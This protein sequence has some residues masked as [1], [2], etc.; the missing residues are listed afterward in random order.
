MK[1]KFNLDACLGPYTITAVRNNGTA[2]AC[3]GK[4]MDTLNICNIT[5]YKGSMLFC[6]GAVYHTRV[7]TAVGSVEYNV[8]DVPEM[9]ACKNKIT[10]HHINM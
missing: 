4:I 7:Y 8:I 9:Y 5:P 1:T 6:Y 3:K 2:K 10:I